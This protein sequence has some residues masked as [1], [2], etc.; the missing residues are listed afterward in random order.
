[1]CSPLQPTFKRIFH[2][3]H[4]L[5]VVLL[6]KGRGVSRRP[7]AEAAI[8]YDIPRGGTRLSWA[9][10]GKTRVQLGQH[11]RHRSPGCPRAATR[12]LVSKSLFDYE[13]QMTDD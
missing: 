1:M 7:G 11:Q 10:P 6:G 2:K 4:R 12:C 13:A 3:L 5:Q 9:A 8:A